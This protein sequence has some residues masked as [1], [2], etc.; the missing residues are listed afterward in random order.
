[1]DH[2]P[3]RLVHGLDGNPVVI[4]SARMCALLARHAGLD[5]FRISHRGVDQEM[6]A[7]LQAMRAAATAWRSSTTGTPDAVKPE[8]PRSSWMTTTQAAAQLQITA[9]GIRKAIDEGRLTAT[10]ADGRWRITREDLEH[11]RARQTRRPNP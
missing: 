6:D 11:Y 9:R 5:E 4:L 1:M 8:P 7:T 2:D 3:R 10:N